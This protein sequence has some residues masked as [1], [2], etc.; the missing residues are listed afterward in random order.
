MK[1][2]KVAHIITDLDLGGAETMLLKILRNFKDYGYEHLVI[3][4]KIESAILRQ[5][6]ERE[7]YRVYVLNF[8]VHNAVVQFF[9]LIAVLKKERPYIAH[10]YLF[11]ADFLGRIA[12]KISKVPVVISSLRN[13]NIGGAVRESLLRITDFL[14]DKVTAVSQRVADAH[15]SKNLTKKDKLEVIYNGVEVEEMVDIDPLVTKRELGIEDGFLLLT[16]ANLEKKKGYNYLFEAL[17]ILKDKDYR[18]TL[19]SIGGGRERQTLES[20]IDSS[21]LK[22]RVKLLGKRED[23]ASFFA[24][25]DIFVL[26]SVWE[27]MPNALLEAMSHGLPVIATRV[28]GVSEIVTDNETGLLVDARD[29]MSLALSIERLFNDGALRQR[30]AHRA[31]GFDKDRFNIKGTVTSFDRLYKGVLEIHGRY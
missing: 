9:R 15:L 2:V 18:F 17:K 4:L 26:P 7:G 25:A 23:I 8:K 29:S 10:T 11:H 30:L 19:L 27:G 12:A 14:V 6:I 3:C 13:E 21:R 24:T 31:K 28:G 1:T 5:Q 16:V 20:M 22:D